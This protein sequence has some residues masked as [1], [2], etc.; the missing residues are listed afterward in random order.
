MQWTAANTTNG[1]TTCGTYGERHCEYTAWIVW[2]QVALAT[3]SLVSNVKLSGVLI[4]ALRVKWFG[5]DFLFT[6]LSCSNIVYAV[7]MLAFARHAIADRWPGSALE[8]TLGG[9]VQSAYVMVYAIV[10]LL[11]ALE[12]WVAMEY[13]LWHRTQLPSYFVVR[14][15]A[16]C[17]ATGV[18]LSAAPAVIAPDTSYSYYAEVFVYAFTSFSPAHIAWMAAVSFVCALTVGFCLRVMILVFR[19]DPCRTYTVDQKR[20]ETCPCRLLRVAAFLLFRFAL[21]WWLDALLMIAFA[22]LSTLALLLH[23]SLYVNA[24]G[25]GLVY[26]L[27]I[28]RFR[29]TKRRIVEKLSGDSQCASATLSVV[30]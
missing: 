8:V 27:F 22:A 13:P 14:L 2:L 11:G 20:T 21:T 9:F 6:T 10:L 25:D 7:A 3:V 4:Y 19:S 23:Y 1:T 30:I 24:I 16:A 28:R 12:M 26:F 15:T 17:V 5:P 18:A 29:Q